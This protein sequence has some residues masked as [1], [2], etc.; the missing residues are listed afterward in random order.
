MKIVFERKEEIKRLKR[1]LKI[2]LFFPSFL[3]IW[4]ILEE[5][6][7]NKIYFFLGMRIFEIFLNIFEET[8]NI[9]RIVQDR[10]F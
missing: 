7:D 8:A 9:S 5:S 3:W 6:K 10:I 1:Y 2:L 4:Y